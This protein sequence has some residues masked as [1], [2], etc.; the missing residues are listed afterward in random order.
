MRA[1]APLV[2]SE[3][4]SAAYLYDAGYRKAPGEEGMLFGFAEIVR[5]FCSWSRGAVLGWF[6]PKQW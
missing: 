1:K 5:D 3:I 2:P 6:D 4:D